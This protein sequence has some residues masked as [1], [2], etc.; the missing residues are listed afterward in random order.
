MMNPSPT[1]IVELLVFVEVTLIQYATVAGH[2]PG[3]NASSVKPKPKKA[4]KVEVTSDEPKGETQINATTPT[5]P[6]P[7]PKAQPKA[8]PQST[9]ARVENKPPE[10]KKEGKGGGKGKR[11]KSE[12]RVEKRKQQCIHFFRGTCQKGD[13][14]RYEHQVGDDGRPVPVGPE[15]LQRFD[16]AVKR[17][18]ETRAQAQ[19]KPKAAPRGGVTASMII[20]EP[21]DLQNR[22]VVSALQALDNED[23]YA[24]LDSGTNAIIVPLHP[25]ME[26][27]VAECQVPG[28]TVT[29]PIVQ[30]YEFEGKKRLVV[31]LPNSAILVSQE[32]LTTIAGWTFVSGPKPRLENSVCENIVYP[33]GAKKSFVLN[34]KN[35]L[36]YLS[37]E[38][39]WLAMN[40]V[41]RNAKRISG[42]TLDELQEMLDTMAHEP[43]PQIYS[44]KTVAVPEPSK[45]V[46]TTVPLTHHFKPNDVRREIIAWFEH[47]H[48]T[49]NQN[50]GRLSGNAASLTFGAQT[51]RGSDRSC[52]IKR[53]L[54]HDYYPLITLVHQLAQNAA[55]SVLPYLGF[56]IL[57]LGP[58][59]NLNQHRDYHNHADYPNHTMKFG[60]YTGGSLQMLRDGQWH[61]YDTECQWMS[62]DALKVVHRVTPVGRGARY[63]ITLYTPGKLDRLTAQDWD[64]LARFGFPIYLYEPLPAKMR[65]LT[66]PSHVMNLSSE[67]EKTQDHDGSRQVAREQYHHRSYEALLSHYIDNTEHLWDDL[68]VPSV[69]DPTDANLVRP[70]TLLDCCKDAQEFMDEYDLNDGHDNGTLYL[71]RVYGHRTR[72]LSYFQAL[73]YH[74]ESN[75]Q[76]GYLW[77]LTNMLRLVFNMANEE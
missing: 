27:E 25:R 75:D 19:A 22:V 40:D 36:P 11:G 24:M 65:R 33:A 12:P 10:N 47:F 23:Y 44:V 6:R 5:T 13:Q 66:T 18:N 37:R 14:C 74:S 58:G 38:L 57:R 52:V 31:A 43:Q 39:F 45:V 16:D 1:E 49:P 8:S 4:N 34:M 62:F 64:N 32:W 17:Y 59:Q 51:G 53:T 69:A 30:V 63:S 9:P 48:P 56:Q 7:K 68:P 26:G 60:K 54:D 28:S 72:M 55:G 15:I 21:D 46:F 35:G 3:V 70:K 50:R 20:L 29:G 71:M 73:L 42:H 61:S 41:A 77:T 67:P 76:H 2:F